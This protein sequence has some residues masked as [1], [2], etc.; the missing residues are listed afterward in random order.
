MRALRKGRAADAVA[1]DELP[2]RQHPQCANLAL[3]PQ[4][5]NLALIFDIDGTLVDSD[6]FGSVIIKRPGVDDLLDWCFANCAA[7]ALWTLASHEWAEAVVDT[8]RCKGRRRE[9]AFVWSAERATSVIP[10]DPNRNDVDGLGLYCGM[11]RQKRLQKVWSG[12]RRRAQG[13][14]PARTLIVEDTPS[15]CVRNY[16]NAIYV[17]TFE[18]T[19]H[20]VADNVDATLHA[21]QRYLAHLQSS[22]LDVRLVEKRCWLE[23][24]RTS[25]LD[26]VAEPIPL[27]A[28]DD[29]LA[30]GN[31]GDDVDDGV[32]G[33]YGDDRDDHDGDDGDYGGRDNEESPLACCC[34]AC[35][36]CQRVLLLSYQV[37]RR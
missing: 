9:W 27:P 10:T 35:L 24:Y 22:V 37:G 20:A 30:D 32:G 5:A 26:H 36:G 14:V 31:D 18:H 16:G 25:L 29:E 8:L 33:D 23:R 13:F 1:A 4:C 11:D 7:V 28:A 2:D 21:L 3:H 17:P 12:A 6:A 15:N 34:P 19:E